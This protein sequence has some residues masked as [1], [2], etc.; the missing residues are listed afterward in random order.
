MCKRPAGGD[1]GEDEGG[2]NT[3]LVRSK[4][5]LDGC[6]TLAEVV[7]RLRSEIV[8]YQQ[9]MEEGWELMGEIDDDYGWLKR[10][11]DPSDAATAGDAQ[12]RA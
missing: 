2:D 11:E 7:D 9:L 3:I 4:W 1:E 12:A 8:Y 5:V 6:T 10:R